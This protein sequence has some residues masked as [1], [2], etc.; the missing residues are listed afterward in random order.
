MFYQAQKQ[1]ALHLCKALIFLVIRAGVIWL[2]LNSS[3]C[4]YYKG[5]KLQVK[6]W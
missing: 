3:F 2:V 6:H 4:G 5:V 1:K